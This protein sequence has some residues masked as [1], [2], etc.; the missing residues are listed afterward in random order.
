MDCTADKV[1][2]DVDSTPI[3]LP[4]GDDYCQTVGYYI[5]TP[6]CLGCGSD[7]V[8]YNAMTMPLCLPVGADYC[9]TVAYYLGEKS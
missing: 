8:F 7:Q 4:I 5:G 3:C 1:Y 9:R 6:L 2:Y